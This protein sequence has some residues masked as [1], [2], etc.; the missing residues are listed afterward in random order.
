MK[1][2]ICIYCSSSNTVP[3]IYFD[4]AREIGKQLVE[5]HYTLVYGG[6]NVGLMGELA[7]TV[8]HHGGKVI[9]VIPQKLV[10]REVAYHESD[11]LIITDTMHERK[12][13][14]EDRAD[15]FVALPGGFGT[16]EEIF[17]VL[18]LKVLHFHNKPII[19]LDVDNFYEPLFEMFERLYREHFVK[20]HY[21]SLYYRAS[22]VAS[23]FEYLSSLQTEK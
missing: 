21:R 16:L 5:Q 6:G 3:S 7:R 10:D 23:V 14:M 1:K 12:E 22:D 17:E 19:F 18:T 4:V 15:A 13:T 2:N 20:E 8:H 9:G 11:E